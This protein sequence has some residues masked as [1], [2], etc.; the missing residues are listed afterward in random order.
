MD[1]WLH[2]CMDAWMHDALLRPSTDPRQAADESRAHFEAAY[3]YRHRGE[4]TL[5]DE[6]E[7]AAA[8]VAAATR[9]PTTPAGAS[10]LGFTHPTTL[11]LLTLATRYV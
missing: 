11:S 6:D 3:A 8:T 10:V 9:R 7:L 1:A 4:Q 5:L 2:G